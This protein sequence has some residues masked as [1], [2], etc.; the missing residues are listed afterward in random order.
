MNLTEMRAMVRRDLHDEDSNNYR[1]A[2]DEIDRHINHA[3]RDFSESVPLEQKATLATISGFRE[4]SISSLS[5]RVMI[6]AAEFPVGQFP[7]GY[8]RFALWGDILTF[9]GEPVPDG[10]NCCIFYGKLHTLD[11]STSTI[12]AQ[13]EDLIPTGACGYSAIE[14]AVYS[15]NRVNIGGTGTPGEWQEWGKNKLD[16]FHSEL[17]R[18]GRK[19]RVR[20][21]QLYQP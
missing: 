9:L 18:L 7:P 1:W 19:N 6:E 2:N 3:L 21:R 20:V 8:Q 17:K 5:N 12:P 11:V 4:I 14:W 16:F 10:S 13:H 15:V